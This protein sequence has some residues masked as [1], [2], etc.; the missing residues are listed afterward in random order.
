ML[1]RKISA[2]VIA[3]VTL[4]LVG[5][6]NENIQ[7]ETTEPV[8][9]VGTTNASSNSGEPHFVPAFEIT[10]WTME[11]LTDNISLCGEKIT[12][13]CKLSDIKEKFDVSYTDLPG[14][15]H[16]CIL[17][18]KN[19]DVAIVSCDAYEN[20][21]AVI[22]NISYGLHM[23]ISGINI[24]GITEKSKADDVEKILGKPNYTQD[25][26]DSYRYI[27]EDNKQVMFHFDK[28]K[29]TVDFYYVINEENTFE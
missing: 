18:H 4:C 14:G 8:E 15:G 22:T 23:K 11:E 7:P 16:N 25:N 20:E 2:A 19:K 13:P 27:F 1:K 9:L 12:L 10:D 3:C 17:S 21:D 5:C 26:G 29:R 28:K 24:M 6:K